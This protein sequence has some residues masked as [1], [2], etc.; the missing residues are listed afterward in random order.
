VGRDIWLFAG[1]E[2]GGEAAATL[3]TLVVSA[4]ASGVDP[5]S[6]FDALLRRVG[7]HSA[8]RVSELTPWA[9]AGELEP[10][11]GHRDRA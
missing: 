2:E 3:D 8:S 9:M 5:R 7:T 4:R 10:Y 6:C 1:S 11:R